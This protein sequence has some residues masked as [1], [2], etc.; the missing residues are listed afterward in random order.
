MHRWRF[1]TSGSAIFV[2]LLSLNLCCCKVLPPSAAKD[3][4]ESTLSLHTNL[5]QTFGHTI[6]LMEERS[7]LRYTDTF[8]NRGNYTDPIADKL[9]E[10]FDKRLH[11]I[12][13]LTEYFH[14]LEAL[15]GRSNKDEVHDAA[16]KF[17]GSLVGLQKFIPENE[18]DLYKNTC[19]GFS[20]LADLLARAITVRIQQKYI[21]QAMDSAA[22][23]IDTL[24]ELLNEELH[25]AD[26]IATNNGNSVIT[27]LITTRNSEKSYTIKVE[28]DKHIQIRIKELEALHS[29]YLCAE[30]LVLSLPKAHNEARANLKSKTHLKDA[31][32]YVTAQGT[33]LGSLYGKIKSSQSN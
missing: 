21:A 20:M 33:E 14:G 30:L 1:I 22:P 10:E 4:A 5:D 17:D 9:A 27:R 25:I 24:C 26:N 31:I 16:T 2:I 28:L 32:S 23:A 18:K 7:Y 11:Y 6:S 15:A 13:I 12:S 29:S 3:L 19:L 8:I